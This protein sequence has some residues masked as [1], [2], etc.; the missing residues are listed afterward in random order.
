[1]LDEPWMTQRMF[2]LGLWKEPMRSSAGARTTLGRTGAEY[3]MG[4]PLV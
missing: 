2:P 3:A 4:H 1:M